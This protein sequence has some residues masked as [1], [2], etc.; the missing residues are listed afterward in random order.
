MTTKT[1]KQS[2]QL[3]IPTDRYAHDVAGMPCFAAVESLP[4]MVGQHSIEISIPGDDQ[5]C[6]IAEACRAQLQTPYVSVGRS[7]TDIALPHPQ[8][9]K[10]P[11]YGD[12]LWAA[13]RHQNTD[14][15]LGL[16]IAADTG[17]LAEIVGQMVKFIPP[18]KENLAANKRRYNSIRKRGKGTT[19]K[20]KPPIDNLT[21]VGVRNLTGQRQRV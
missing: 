4:V 14:S 21:A 5:H 20:R 12:T 16:I 17:N 15:A 11:G 3:Q 7:R 6:A 13:V 10:K 9:V 1:K 8:G 18:H 2:K 19:K